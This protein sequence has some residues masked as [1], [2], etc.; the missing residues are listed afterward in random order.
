MFSPSPPLLEQFGGNP[1]KHLKNSSE[2]VYKWRPS[3]G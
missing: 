3:I 1:E 2:G